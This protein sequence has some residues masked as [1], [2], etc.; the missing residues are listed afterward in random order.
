[1]TP[2]WS[3]AI[4]SARWLR[5][6]AEN[7]CAA[8]LLAMFLCFI[9]QIVAR[10]VFNYPLGWTDEVSVLCWIWCVLWGAVFLLRER[11]EVRFDIIYSSAGERTRR[12]LAIITGLVVIAMFAIALPAVIAYVTF[13]KVERS[14]YLGIR[15]DYLYSIYVL[16]SVAVIVR[17]ATLVWRA[18]R[19]QAPDIEIGGGSAL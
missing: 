10:Y 7:I 3:R 18:I 2:S 4:R 5:R 11:D 8:L 16:F 15:L 13:L 14:A 1:M 19:G 17:Y 6:R 9:L 12:I